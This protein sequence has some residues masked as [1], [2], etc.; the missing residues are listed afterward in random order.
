MIRFFCIHTPDMLLIRTSRQ[1]EIHCT[2]CCHHRMIHVIVA[3]LSIPSD[4]EQI[5]DF[6]QPCSQFT[7]PVI[8]AKISWVCFLYFLDMKIKNF[9]KTKSI[10]YHISRQKH[11]QKASADRPVSLFSFMTTP[12][13]PAIPATARQIPV[14]PD[15]QTAP[16]RKEGTRRSLLKDT[17]TLLS[18]FVSDLFPR[19]NADNFPALKS[20]SYCTQNTDR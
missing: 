11:P 3:M 4:T 13:L 10:I 17:A 5:F 1:K 2:K 15:I 16:D 14:L 19:K 20:V 9:Q 8:G 6:I 18:W 12:N 7:H